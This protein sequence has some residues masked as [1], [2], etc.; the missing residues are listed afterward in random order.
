M[1]I[2]KS[3]AVRLLLVTCF[4]FIGYDGDAIAAAPL[5]CSNLTKLALKD[6]TFNKPIYITSAKSVAAN[7]S[8]G[9]PA[10]CDVRATMRPELDFVIKLPVTPT[11][12]KRFYY[13]GGGSMDGSFK[14]NDVDAATKLTF[15]VATTNGGHNL[16]PGQGEADFAYPSMTNL[17]A[18]QKVKDL[19]YRAHYEGAM[20]AKK[21]IKAH[22]GIDPIRSYYWGCS[23]GGRE[24][25]IMAQRYPDVYDGYVIGAPLTSYFSLRPVWNNQNQIG[26]IPPTLYTS[27][28][29]MTVGH[30]VHEPAALISNSLASDP[31]AYRNYGVAKA[32]AYRKA[33]YVQCDGLDGLVDGIIADPEK[34]TFIYSEAGLKAALPMCAGD[35]DAS[36]CF[37]YEQIKTLV[38]INNPP[39]DSRGTKLTVALLGGGSV[40][41]SPVYPAFS[42][43][44]WDYFKY[45]A[46]NPPP[47]P[48]WNWLSFNFDIDPAR[49][50][51]SGIIDTLDATDP[52]L[53]G[54]KYHGAKIIM[55]HG[56]ADPIIPT[57]QSL[58]YYKS[59]KTRM[60]DISDFF[61]YYLVPGI[62]HCGGGPGCYDRNNYNMWVKPL[63]DWVENGKAPGAIIGSQVDNSGKVLR[64]RPQCPYP[65]IA[66]PIKT[67]L[68]VV[69]ANDAA[70]FVC[71]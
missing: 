56:A 43:R 8:T 48:A 44:A 67:P 36:N 45:L 46:F 33:L 26:V 28:A 14:M 23:N 20:L 55:W 42:G 25:L 60:G 65:L 4:L 41:I 6:M 5:S 49:V 9:M 47:G 66:K 30:T 63:M 53:W 16:L 22:Y 17:N 37:T 62:D 15:A 58:E 38:R 57:L 69:E 54:V 29:N 11:W 59:V 68:A 27:T 19:G 70:N 64:M 52:N 34:C 10:H 13:T 3:F 71:Q 7:S 51:A 18:A 1:K 61:R 39:V 21:I 40:P 2:T 12:N 31:T 35:V 50:A 32:D 24:G